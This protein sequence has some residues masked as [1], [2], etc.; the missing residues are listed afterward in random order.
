MEHINAFHKNQWHNCT[1]INIPLQAKH[2][3]TC[4]HT[5]T[6]M[7]ITHAH[8]HTHITKTS[9]RDTE[10]KLLLIKILLEEVN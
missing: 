5:H 2:K 4:T 10:K 3:K 8:T 7:V 9:K 6:V 1:F